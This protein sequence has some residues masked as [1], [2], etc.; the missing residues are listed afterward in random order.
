MATVPAPV[1]AASSTTASKRASACTPSSPP[2]TRRAVS[3]ADQASAVVRYVSTASRSP[4]ISRSPADSSR[5]PSRTTISSPV[6]AASGAAVSRVRS[7]VD[8]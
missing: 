6:R 1:A 5:M 3:P 8:A 7:S 4:R 2:G